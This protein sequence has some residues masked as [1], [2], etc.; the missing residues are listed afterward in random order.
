M[1]SSSAGSV[2]QLRSAISARP[3]LYI[4]S[5]IRTVRLTV[6]VSKSVL[7]ALRGI[8][9][10]M[11]KR[12]R[13]TGVFCILG[14]WDRRVVRHPGELEI[15]RKDLLYSVLPNPGSVVLPS[16]ILLFVCLGLPESYAYSVECVGILGCPG[17]ALIL[18]ETLESSQSRDKSIPTRRIFS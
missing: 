6:R 9:V 8:N 12:S 4:C 1:P 16:G 13:A 17:I 11:Q 18:A 14:N 15:N 3:L 10:G 5:S 2:S 7:V